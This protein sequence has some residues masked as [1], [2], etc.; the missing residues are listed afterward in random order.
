MTTGKKTKWITG[1]LAGLLLLATVSGIYFYNEEQHYKADAGRAR[2]AQ[3]SV[4][5]VK[6][7][8]EK[9]IFDIRAELALV[10]VQH[11]TLGQKLADSERL[12]GEKQLQ[13]DK[14]LAENA[15]VTALRRQLKELRAEKEK[16]NR[17]IQELLA[18]NLQIQG[19][20]EQLARKVELLEREKQELQGRLLDAD[21][22]G[23]RA[24]NFRVE[25]MRNKKKVTAKA[26]RTNE[27]NV[28]F[29]LPANLSGET[30]G[31][32]KMYLVV[33]DPKGNPVKDKSAS[34]LTLENGQQIIPVS[35]KTISTSAN[36]QRVVFRT[37]LGQKVKSGGIYKIQVFAEDG[38]IGTSEVRMN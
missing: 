25:M 3:D 6:Q 37:E 17:Q 29:D 24:A 16:L 4:L 35:T 8:L 14:L 28:S 30:R 22:K 33:L 7:L 19:A 5:A 36:P 2:L 20:N 12:L 9:E 31:E 38:L 21:R 18:E 26:K 27:I 15:T 34:V 23:N 13:I 32:K 11:G 1:A 10:K